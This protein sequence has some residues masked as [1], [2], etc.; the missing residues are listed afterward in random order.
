MICVSL[1]PSMH[2]IHARVCPLKPGVTPDICLGSV[3]F[4]LQ[5][6]SVSHAYAWFP[7]PSRSCMLP[8][9]MHQKG[10]SYRGSLEI[11]VAHTCSLSY[12]HIHL[13]HVCFAG[14]HRRQE[15]DNS[16]G[17]EETIQATSLVIETLPAQVHH[18]DDDTSWSSVVD[19][20]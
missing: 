15:D 7:P 1:D 11:A 5:F 14:H 13:L 12:L 4:N 17:F 10:S 9:P 18:F 19:L 6:L 8:Q 16:D 20:V 3:L 2:L